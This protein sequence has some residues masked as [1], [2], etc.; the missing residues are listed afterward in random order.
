MD[1][2]TGVRA[3]TSPPMLQPVRVVAPGVARQG[4]PRLLAP[5]KSAN[6]TRQGDVAP[7]GAVLQTLQH[8]S[9]CI[10]PAASVAGRSP[11]VSTPFHGDGSGMTKVE[12]TVTCPLQRKGPYCIQSTASSPISTQH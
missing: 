10:A 11:G 7:L 8:R 5:P 12:R 4:R 9:R 1:P 3:N 6:V 2:A